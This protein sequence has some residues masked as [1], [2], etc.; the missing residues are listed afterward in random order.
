MYTKTFTHKKDPC[1]IYCQIKF[2]WRFDAS[3]FVDRGIIMITHSD[4]PSVSMQ[5]VTEPFTL[6]LLT[7][8][9]NRHFKVNILRH[10]WGCHVD[11]AKIRTA[12]SCYMI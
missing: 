12:P 5:E 4:E 1:K 7:L 8:T 11:L 9:C 10:F 3:C 2:N 6:T